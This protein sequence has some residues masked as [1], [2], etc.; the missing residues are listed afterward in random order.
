MRSALTLCIQARII[1]VRFSDLWIVK[2]SPQISS[3]RV[4]EAAVQ[5][6]RKQPKEFSANGLH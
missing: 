6:F 2:D 1:A 4:K 5:W 3:V